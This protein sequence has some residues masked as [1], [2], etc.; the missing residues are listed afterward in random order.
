MTR[1][2]R[3]LRDAPAEL[4][5]VAPGHHVIEHGE[6]ELRLPSRGSASS[7]SSA[8]RALSTQVGRMPR[9]VSWLAQHF[10]VRGIVVD[11]EHAAIREHPRVDLRDRLLLRGDAET[12]AEPEHRAFPV[13]LVTPV[14]PPI[15]STSRRTIERPKPVPP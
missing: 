11:D 6:L 1:E 9:C 5:A 4:E 3:I 12:G 10:A 15:S 2:S 13:A 7:V 14:S 8:A